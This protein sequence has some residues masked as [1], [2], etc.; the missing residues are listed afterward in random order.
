MSAKQSDLV[1]IHSRWALLRLDAGIKSWD[2]AFE[3]TREFNAERPLFTDHLKIVDVSG[4]KDYTSL[5]LVFT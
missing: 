4:H 1:K 5:A 2:K 3:Y